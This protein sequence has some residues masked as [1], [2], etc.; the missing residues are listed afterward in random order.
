MSNLVALSQQSNPVA[1]LIL[2]IDGFSQVF[3]SSP[4][5]RQWRIGDAGVYIGMPGLTIGGLIDDPNS[6]PVID[7]D[8]STKTVNQQLD[9]E[10]GGSGSY[11]SLRIALTDDMGA[12]T[13]LFAPGS[14]VPDVLGRKARAYLAFKGGNHKTDSYRLITGFI[15]DLEYHQGHVVVVLTHAIKLEEIELF[16][17][18]SLPLSQ[19]LHD[20]GTS[21]SV[22]GQGPYLMP[23]SGAG[24][25]LKTFLRINDEIIEYSS[26]AEEIDGDSIFAFSQRGAFGT[27]VVQH[28]LGDDTSTFYE[29]S[30]DCISLILALLLSNPDEEFIVEDVPVTAFN[31]VTAFDKISNAILFQ[32]VDVVEEFGIVVGD[33]VSVSGATNPGNNFNTA[34]M[35]SIKSIGHSPLGSYI[36]LEDGSDLIDETGTAALVTFKSQFN[37]LPVGCGL[38]GIEVDIEK[39]LEVKNTS[40]NLQN[41]KFYLS[42]GMTAKSFI[43]EQLCLPSGLAQI[44]RNGKISV[45]DNSQP[46]TSAAT[47]LVDSNTITEKGA[48][49][50]VNKRGTNNYFYNAVSWKYH[51][52]P[53]SVEP[54]Q[55]APYLSADSIARVKRGLK[56]L[57]IDALGLVRDDTTTIKI[58]RITKGIFARY[59]YAAESFE[60]EVAWGSGIHIE[61]GDVC[62]FKGAGLNV[63]DAKQGTRGIA[64]KLMMVVNRRFGFGGAIKLTLLDTEFVTTGRF[65]VIA[66]S[67]IIHEAWDR[68][69]LVLGGILTDS[70]DSEFNKW[71]N[72]VGERVLIRS[73]DWTFQK[74]TKLKGFDQLNKRVA[75]IDEIDEDLTVG[76]IDGVLYLDIP[77]YDESDARI[78]SLYKKTCVYLN[79]RTFLV[80]SESQ[81]IVYLEESWL[82]DLG[83]DG[84]LNIHNADYSNDFETQVLKKELFDN[85]GTNVCKVTLKKPLPYAP[86]GDE[87]VDLIGFKDGGLPYR[88]R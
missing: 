14:V 29:L 64:N 73:R 11:Q 87:I 16:T 81:Q 26:T 28:E 57:Q 82:N 37:V 66:P 51:V 9:I 83:S 13:E 21:V 30:G 54:K 22:E 49:N 50:I 65:G 62:I 53:I 60:V 47:P 85:G 36:V 59:Q 17:P 72:Y 69:T 38:T 63:A 61:I 27:A 76:L 23:S 41:Y 45:L 4:V 52:D 70:V 80:G 25:T 71:K 68:K 79:K 42:E 56:L 1:N 43:E 3:G 10:K 44:P 84:Y 7:L 77:N 74:I 86:A 46:L 58:D 5:R 34:N 20:I 75:Y 67:S 40:T 35:K 15:D 2:E 88:I 78:D 18:I 31:Y 8:K 48:Q 12:I 32:G 19:I 33:L 39:F 55:V 6:M 24:V